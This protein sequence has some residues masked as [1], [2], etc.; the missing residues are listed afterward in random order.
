MT[1]R[2]IRCFFCGAVLR[3]GDP[4]KRAIW[5]LCATC[6]EAIKLAS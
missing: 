5:D 2:S 3:S 1:L 6:R 4:D